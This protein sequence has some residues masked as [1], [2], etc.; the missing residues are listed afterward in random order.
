MGLG[1]SS[2]IEVDRSPLL[3]YS[4]SRKRTA[5]RINFRSD[6]VYE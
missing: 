5:V 2:W 3:C 6:Y 1:E 4:L